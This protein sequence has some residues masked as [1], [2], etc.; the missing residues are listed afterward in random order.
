[1]LVLGDGKVVA[2]GPRDEV[3]AKV[4]KQPQAQQAKPQ[5]APAVAQP[6]QLPQPK[7]SATRN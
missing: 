6:A 1:L 3:L 4:T 5:V 7:I 2:Y